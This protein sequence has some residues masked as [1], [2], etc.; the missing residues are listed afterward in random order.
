MGYGLCQLAGWSERGVASGGERP[1]AAGMA[2]L[3]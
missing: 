3:L 1:T 2:V